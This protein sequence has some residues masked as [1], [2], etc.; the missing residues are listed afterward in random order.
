MPAVVIMGKDKSLRGFIDQ[1]DR[2]GRLRR[3]SGADWDLEI[4]ALTDANAKNN[5]Y[6]LLMTPYPLN[7]G[8]TRRFQ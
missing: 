6:A 3:I 4:G 1:L 5:K 8:N 7:T 2:S